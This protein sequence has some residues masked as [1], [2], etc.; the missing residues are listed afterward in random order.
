MNMNMNMNNR[1][2]I[3]HKLIK[4]GARSEEGLFVGFGSDQCSLIDVP[5]GVVQCSVVHI[6][7]T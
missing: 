6:I 3:K 4:R 1:H 5:G 2:I 7:D